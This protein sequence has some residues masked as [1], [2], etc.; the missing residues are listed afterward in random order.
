MRYAFI[1]H[2]F[3]AKD[4]ARKYP[5]AKYFPDSLI[6]AFLLRK[7]PV[8]VSEIKGL[9]SKTGQTAE[10][11]FIGLP[12]TPKQMMG[13][14]PLDVVEHKIIKCVELAAK[15][16]AEVV[17]LGAFSAVV[18]DGGITIAKS[19]PIAV[20]TGNSYTVTTAIQGVTK[21]AGLVGLDTANAT[22]AVVGATGSIG[23]T[24][25][26]VLSRSFGQTIVVG[27]NPERTQ[28]I[29]A[30]VGATKASTDINDINS[31]DVVITVTSADNPI[32]DPEHL[33]PGAVVCDVSRPRNVS[34]RVAQERPDVLVIEGGVVKLPGNVD[35]GFDIGF[36][37]GTAFACMSETM[38]LGLEGRAE[39][40][41][42]G[43]DV[44]VAQVDEMAALAEKHGFELAGFRAFEHEIGQEAIDR[45]RAARTQAKAPDEQNR[46]VS[47]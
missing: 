1:I 22:L 15:E 46:A 29:G 25:A 19:S 6:E 11:M 31:A 42:L 8:V 38:M 24:C 16:G 27:R 35:L 23:K 32:I 21:A 10:G 7:S 12:L 45:A 26:R 28:Q 39:N 43:K 41:T 4:I 40:F 18:G 34:H 17:G 36:P 2:P 30:E 13:G 33:K 14:V 3:K 37:P 47:R 44:S 5:I 20:T 9:V